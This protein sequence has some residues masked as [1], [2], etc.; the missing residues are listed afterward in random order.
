M[1]NRTYKTL[2]LSL[3]LGSAVIVSGCK[4][5]GTKADSGDSA[6]PG[7][8]LA[9]PVP[10]LG[11]KT[12]NSM[13]LPFGVKLIKTQAQYEALGDPQIFEGIDFD[14][15]DLVIAALGKRNT[16]GY[17]IQIDSLQ[18]EGDT[19]VVVGKASSPAPSDPVTKVV[20]YPYAAAV[21][22]NTQATSVVQAID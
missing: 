9:E 19:L 5:G 17:S 8:V 15:H 6:G 10:I 18:T 16:G 21:I 2:T 4:G 7:V 14:K 12:G 11:N 1:R 22:A 13:A 20:T 3:L